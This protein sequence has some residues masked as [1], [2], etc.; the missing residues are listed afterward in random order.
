M[1]NSKRQE[2]ELMDNTE[3]EY[4]RNKKYKRKAKRTRRII[5]SATLL[6]VIIANIAFSILADKRLL[7]TDI[8]DTRYAKDEFTLYTMT[9]EFETLIRDEVIPKIDAVNLEKKEK[10]EDEIKLK[11]IFCADKDLVEGDTYLR[12]ANYTARELELKFPDAIEV[13]Y[14][15]IDKNPSAVQKYKVNSASSIY[16]SSVILEF[17]SEYRHISYRTFL[18]ASS[19]DDAPWAYNGEKKF[20]SS[21]LSLTRAES[22]ILCITTNHGEDIYLENGEVA[23]EYTEFIKVIEGAGYIVMPIDLEH[24]DIPKDCRT[25]LTFNPKEDFKA[26]GSLGDNGVSEIEKLDKFID[27]AYN[28]IYVCDRTTPYLE[29]LEEYLEEWGIKVARRENLAGELENASLR[30]EEMNIDADNGDKLIANYVTSGGG[31]ALMEDLISLTYPPTTVFSDS[32]YVYAPENYSKKY[33]AAD[34]TEGI[35]ACEFYYYYKN[36]VS[37]SRYDVLTTNASAKASIGNEVFEMAN[38]EKRFSLMTYTRETRQLQEDNYSSVNDSS[39]VFAFASTDFFKNEYL[40]SDAYGNTDVLLTALRETSG[41]IIPVNL[42]FKAFYV[43]DVSNSGFLAN[44]KTHMILLAIIP[45]CI[46]FVA[47]I[48]VNVKRKHK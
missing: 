23:E 44:A 36:G 19:D 24:D 45:T 21:M 15:N 3:I 1:D 28:F 8:S 35:E 42:P 43:Y 2:G 13:E 27:N 5:T 32:T 26:F 34:E 30:D 14:I 20:A 47:G 48:V 22:P 12:Y 40:G 29:N 4:A 10:G 25:I 41:E 37:R 46:V 33:I 38:N 7:F 16:S 17:G 18:T 6:L 31:G 9:D 11:I 39:Y